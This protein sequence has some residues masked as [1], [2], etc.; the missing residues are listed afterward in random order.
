M[1]ELLVKDILSANLSLCIYMEQPVW[2]RP[3]PEVKRKIACLE[4]VTFSE[5]WQEARFEEARLH[6]LGSIMPD[7]V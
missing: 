6:D 7:T 5:L 2:G 1:V 3:M 4:G